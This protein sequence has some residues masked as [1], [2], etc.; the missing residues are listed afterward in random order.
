MLMHY[1]I[2]IFSDIREFIWNKNTLSVTHSWI[3]EKN[4]E[5][6][7]DISYEEL[8]SVIHTST[9][10]KGFFV[11]F[12]RLAVSVDDC[13]C[14]EIL[15]M[16]NSILVTGKKFF[17]GFGDIQADNFFSGFGKIQAE[18]FSG[19]KKIRADNFFS[20]FGKIQADNFFQH[21]FQFGWPV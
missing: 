5:L 9:V 4:L 17:I 13:P 2:C 16:S 11:S 1:F 18:I 19:F 15:V 7:W 14:R 21:S 20:R 10:L 12:Y 8:D 6:L 3:V